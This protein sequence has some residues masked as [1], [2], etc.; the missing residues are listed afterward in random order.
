LERNQD[1]GIGIINRNCRGVKLIAGLTIKTEFR[2][3]FKLCR[4]SRYYRSNVYSGEEQ[5]S[6]TISRLKTIGK[7]WLTLAK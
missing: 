1:I 4:N 6:K 7:F 3:D 2:T 5:A